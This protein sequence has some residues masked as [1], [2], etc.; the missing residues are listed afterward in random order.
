[1]DWLCRPWLGRAI[2]FRSM[3]ISSDPKALRGVDV[4]REMLKVRLCDSVAERHSVPMN[5]F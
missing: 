1:M 3:A 5:G 4:D 2:P